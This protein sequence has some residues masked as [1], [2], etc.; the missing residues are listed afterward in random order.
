MLRSANELFDAAEGLVEIT[1]PSRNVFTVV[2]P[3]ALGMKCGKQVGIFCG[4]AA[5]LHP[6]KAEL[7]L[8][9][10]VRLRW[11]AI[12]TQEGHRYVVRGVVQSVASA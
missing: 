8:H 3:I 11:N 9:R 6:V 7:V 1:A 4:K 2:R 12:Q 5:L 10:S